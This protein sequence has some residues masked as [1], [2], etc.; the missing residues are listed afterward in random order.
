V[1]D[2]NQTMAEKVA[3]QIRQAGGQALAV[4]ANVLERTS[5]ETA[6][7]KIHEQWGPIDL[8]VNGAGGNKPDAT[9]TA[10]Q[11]FFQIP[12]ES[13]QW[14]FNLN[15]VGTILTSQVFVPDL[16]EKQAGVVINIASMAGIRPLTRVLA[17]SAAKA[18]VANFTQWLAVHLAQ[19]YSP[20]IRVNAI[21]PGFFLTEQNRFLLVDDQG[22][23][24]PRGKTIL[25]HTPGARYGK[26]E[27]LIGTLL[28]LVSDAARFVSGTVIPVD[29][30]FS[31]FGGV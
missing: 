8:L 4:T 6:R 5:L 26:P 12:A 24:T 22:E 10:D 30:G 9:A 15:C 29:G 28:W 13:I 17:Y 20:D 2:L 14:V 18:G 27:D 1:L 31:A 21:A 19:E 25:E 11:P 23:P 3:Q 7:Q 16:V